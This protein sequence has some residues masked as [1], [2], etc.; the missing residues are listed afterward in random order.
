MDTKLGYADVSEFRGLVRIEIENDK[1]SAE[2]YIDYNSALELLAKLKRL[3]YDE[4]ETNGFVPAPET[5]GGTAVSNP[6]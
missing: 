2:V 5:Q 6:D 3:M 4:T 1:S